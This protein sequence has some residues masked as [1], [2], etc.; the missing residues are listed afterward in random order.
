MFTSSF[1]KRLCSNRSF[2]IVVPIYKC[3][4]NLHLGADKSKDCKGLYSESMTG[5]N[6]DST[7]TLQQ[8]LCVAVPEAVEPCSTHHAWKQAVQ[9]FFLGLG[10]VSLGAWVRPTALGTG[11]G[12]NAGKSSGRFQALCLTL[13][14]GAEEGFLLLQHCSH[15]CLLKNK[16]QKR[17]VRKNWFWAWDFV[18][19]KPQSSKELVQQ[20]K[21][22]SCIPK[23]HM[24]NAYVFKPVENT[25]NV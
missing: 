16:P 7:D 3:D 4:Y 10:W 24:K 18:Q 25:S 8:N 20:P 5:A 11:R 6:Q 23:L 9:E 13:A 12:W 19:E 2:H 17:K 21:Y 15:R 14:V 22:D 1:K